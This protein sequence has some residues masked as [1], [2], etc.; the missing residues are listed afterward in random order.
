MVEKEEE[1][2]N[3]LDRSDNPTDRAVTV[4][5]DG[6]GIFVIL[7]V[8]QRCYYGMKFGRCR[9]LHINRNGNVVHYGQDA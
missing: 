9:Y 4:T 2:R 8:R 6:C 1:I 5:E 7:R 3:S